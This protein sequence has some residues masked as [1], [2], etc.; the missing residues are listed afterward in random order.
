[1][2]AGTIVRVG[3]TTNGT[4][5]YR[6]VLTDGT[7]IGQ[8]VSGCIECECESYVCESSCGQYQVTASSLDTPATYNSGLAAT[9]HVIGCDGVLSTWS[10]PDTSTPIIVCACDE[11]QYNI[12]APF[13]AT[14]N[15]TRIG[16]CSQPTTTTEA[17]TTTTTTVVEPCECTSYVITNLQNASD[18][19]I[20]YTDCNTGAVSTSRPGDFG[21]GSFSEL[22]SITICSQSQPTFEFP[23]TVTPNG[24]CCGASQPVTVVYLPTTTTTTTAPTTT[25][26]FAMTTTTT[27]SSVTCDETNCLQITI[28]VGEEPGVL[29]YVN[30]TGSLVQVNLNPDEQ[31]AFCYCDDGGWG[32]A[33]GEASIIMGPEPC[34]L[35]TTTT[36]D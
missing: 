24:D 5:S 23:A 2:L 26:T 3:V 10:I 32:M 14:I 8:F 6:N 4:T 34:Q 1:M 15:V 36:I 7:L 13:G 11:I 19:T 35:D 33:A 9:A 22:Q 21:I 17:P 25:T 20:S 16:D 30:C 31:Y 12:F 27:A 29:E 28:Q 18:Y